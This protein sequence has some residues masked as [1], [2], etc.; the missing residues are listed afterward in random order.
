MTDD[1][2]WIYSAGSHTSRISTSLSQGLLSARVNIVPIHGCLATDPSDSPEIRIASAMLMSG[3]SH[4][5]TIVDWD[6]NVVLPAIQKA[7]LP[8]G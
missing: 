7:T 4:S 6:G 8:S 5:C 2:P 3:L 1:P